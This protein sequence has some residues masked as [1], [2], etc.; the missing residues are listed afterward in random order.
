MHESSLRVNAN[1]NNLRKESLN[2][3]CF[4]LSGIVLKNL[5]HDRQNLFAQGTGNGFL[6]KNIGTGNQNPC[7]FHALYSTAVTGRGR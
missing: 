5:A 4:Y 6:D 7:T 3:L 1:S 2:S